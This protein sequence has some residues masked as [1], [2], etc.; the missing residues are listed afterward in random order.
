MSLFYTVKPTSKI[1]GH[2][3]HMY[4]LYI[5]RDMDYIHVDNKNKSGEIN[6]QIYMEINV[7]IY[8]CPEFIKYIYLSLQIYGD[9]YGNKG[10]YIDI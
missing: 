4:I 9:L 2:I 10:I 6:L 8:R 5:E 3:D 7:C 1:C